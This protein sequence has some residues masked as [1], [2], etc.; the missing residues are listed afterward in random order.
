MENFWGLFKRC[1]KGT[2]VLVEPFH[3][4]RN[5]DSECF[6]FNTRNMIDGERFM[7]AIAG[8]SGKR[9]T[10]RVLTGVT[11]FHPAIPGFGVEGNRARPN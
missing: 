5:L 1:I 11:E 10:Y 8:I 2:H 6:R 9:L 3:L 7:Q 4:F